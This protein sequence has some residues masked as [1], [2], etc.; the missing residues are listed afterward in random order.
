ME[1]LAGV[2]VRCE[3]A[4]EFRYRTMPL[5]KDAL[6][7]I[8]SQSGETA[9]SLAALRDAK[10]NGLKTLA[11]V[12]VV[13]SSIARE[14]DY[15]LYTLAGPEISVAS[16]KAYSLQAAL[17]SAIAIYLSLLRGRIDEI[18]ARTMFS[19]LCK[20]LP[21][22]VDKVLSQKEQIADISRSI[23][24]AEHLFYIG[25]GIDYYLALEA[26]LKLKEISY[27]HSE[28]YPSGELKHGT[29][30]LI[31]E[32]TPVFAI[33][34]DPNLAEKSLLAVHEVASRGAHVYIIS[35]DQISREHKLPQCKKIILPDA[36]EHL[37]PIVAATAIQLLAYFTA[38]EKG[39]DV[40]KPRNLAKSVTVE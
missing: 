35:T 28:A 23:I 26:S 1:S 7:V 14:A 21:M 29:I 30:S 10:A 24:G 19:S 37:R 34:T 39:L 32:G 9:D 27:I 12:N 4:S 33:I 16:T 38:K 3:L 8:I 22:L 25:R 15:V 40:D 5:N 6:C 20:D 17:L 18:I 13:G 31:T 36:P 11:I 2:P